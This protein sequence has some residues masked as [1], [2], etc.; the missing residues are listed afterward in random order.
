M[1]T[2]MDKSLQKDDHIVFQGGTHQDAI[3]MGVKDYLKLA[4][5][6]VLDFTYRMG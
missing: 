1:E 4:Q 2:V 6:K 5:P 3:H